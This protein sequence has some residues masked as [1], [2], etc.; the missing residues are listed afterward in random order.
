MCQG[1]LPT[2]FDELSG[3][4]CISVDEALRLGLSPLDLS[5]LELLSDSHWV[6]DAAAEHQL[7]LDNRPV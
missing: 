3:D 2:S 5:D 7:R 1:E 4:E 6:A